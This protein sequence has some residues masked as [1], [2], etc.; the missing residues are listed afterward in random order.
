MMK[1][2]ERISE[3]WESLIEDLEGCWSTMNPDQ[4]DFIRSIAASIKESS[5]DVVNGTLDD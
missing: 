4:R 3:D 5:A 1:K 2:A